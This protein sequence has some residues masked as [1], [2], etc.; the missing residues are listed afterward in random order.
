MNI[1]LHHLT[2]SKEQSN[3]PL[4]DIITMGPTKDSDGRSADVQTF[5]IVFTCC[6]ELNL[7]SKELAASL[8]ITRTDNA[9]VWYL[10]A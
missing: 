1:L 3:P 4:L 5:L 7:D 8:G 6:D 9:W 10:P 2:T